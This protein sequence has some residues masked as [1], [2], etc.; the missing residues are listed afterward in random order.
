MDIM[1]GINKQARDERKKKLRIRYVAVKNSDIVKN[2][3]ADDLKAAVKSRRMTEY[4]NNISSGNIKTARSRNYK[5]QSACG[6]LYDPYDINFTNWLFQYLH[7]I[8]KNK[9]STNFIENVIE[10]ECIVKLYSDTFS[11]TEA[12]TNAILYE[13]AALTAEADQGI[14]FEE[15]CKALKRYLDVTP[16]HETPESS[17][18]QQNSEARNLTEQSA[19]Q[20]IAVALYDF[21][22]SKKG[23]LSF[24]KEDLL[25]IFPTDGKWCKAKKDELV[26]WVPKNYI[27]PFNEVMRTGKALKDYNSAQK[28]SLSFSKNSVITI[29]KQYLNWAD[30]RE[31]VKVKMV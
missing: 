14:S 21:T 19:R 9:N 22:A 30:I 15:S 27:L 29:H 10:P 28:N 20:D 6:Q 12:D 17:V 16:P 18:L 11:T 31:E 4:L 3:A 7:E 1:S 24:N 13:T 26:G 2:M 23:H 8:F 5:P 25:V